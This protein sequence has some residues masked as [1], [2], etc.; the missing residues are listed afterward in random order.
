MKEKYTWAKR[1]GKG[2]GTKVTLISTSKW[3]EEFGMW[4]REK[5]VF[6]GGEKD[7]GKGWVCLGD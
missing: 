6:G 7:V 2:S 4:K 3:G 1:A 5:R